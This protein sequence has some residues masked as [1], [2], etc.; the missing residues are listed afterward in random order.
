MGSGENGFARGQGA[1]PTDPPKV[2]NISY[3]VTCPDGS[4]I[5]LVRTPPQTTVPLPVDV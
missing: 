5:D 4:W 1:K 2:S 3:A